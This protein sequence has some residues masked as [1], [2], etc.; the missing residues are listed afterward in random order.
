[1]GDFRVDEELKGEADYADYGEGKADTRRGH[2]EAAG[3]EEAVGFER[4]GVWML[5]VEAWGGEVEGPEAVEGAYVHGESA[6]GKHCH[7]E[8]GGPD[9]AEGKLL[10]NLLVWFIDLMKSRRCGCLL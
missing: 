5:G 8:V 4:W 2:A 9:A 3:E 10:A 7:D 6:V 1:M